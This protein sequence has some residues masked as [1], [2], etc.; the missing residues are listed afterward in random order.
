M[1]ALVSDIGQRVAV[2]GLEF[3]DFKDFFTVLGTVFDDLVH[4]LKLVNQSERTS[5]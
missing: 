4:V 3:V 5:L 1:V 2:Q